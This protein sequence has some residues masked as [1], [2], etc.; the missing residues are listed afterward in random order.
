MGDIVPIWDKTGIIRMPTMRAE[1]VDS[2][3]LL[4]L[5]ARII[6]NFSEPCDA[7]YEAVEQIVHR[8]I[9]DKPIVEFSEDDEYLIADI[10]AVGELVPFG[11]AI[12]LPKNWFKKPTEK[13]S[14]D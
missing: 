13:T 9:E 3:L 7:F 1:R 14:K 11:Y 8:V 2:G 10:I 12:Y 6:P 4:S 5:I